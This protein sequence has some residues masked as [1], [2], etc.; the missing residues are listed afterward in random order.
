MRIDAR[1]LNNGAVVRVDVC[2]IGAG[3]AGMT[4][5][6][7]LAGMQHK[8]A[9]LESGGNRPD[10]QADELSKGELSGILDQPLHD[11]HARQVGGTANH[12]IIKMADKRNG[13][14]HAP[15]D[16]IDFE[17]REH[18]PYSGW[19]I[20]RADLDPYYRRV[21]EACEIGPY[22]YTGA[23][24][25]DAHAP[26]LLDADETLESSVFTFG[27]TN[28]FTHDWPNQFAQSDTVDL[29]T[30]AT[31]VELLTDPN[32][33]RV[34]QALVRVPGGNEIRFEATEFVIAAGGFDTARLLLNSNR[35]FAHGLGN[36]HD[37]VGRYYIDHGVVLHGYF[38]PDDL[39][40]MRRLAF[41]DLRLVGASSVLGKFTLS[42]ATRRA[43][44][45]RNLG[46]MIFPKPGDVDQEAFES[47]QQ[48]AW[49]L[50]GR[51]WPAPLGEKL[52]SI[53]RGW[54]YLAHV[55]YQRFGNDAGLMPGLA[56]GGWSEL[57]DLE[58]RFSRLELISLVE[59]TPNPNN[60]VTLLDDRDPLGCRRI[61]AHMD[62]N[63]D[64][65]ASVRR[66]EALLVEALQRGGFGRFEPH[67]PGG[68][69][70]FYSRTAHHIMGTAR[71]CDD[72]RFGVVDRDCKVHD[73]AN[74]H[75]ASSA[76]FPT[77]GYANP[78]LT[79]L[80]LTIRL[81]DTIKARLERSPTLGGEV[82]EF[83][84]STGSPE[85]IRRCA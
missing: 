31:V 72:P 55:F 18:I 27:A 43:E 57:A 36:Q 80:A 10:R 5:A 71:M 13:F 50:H 40:I 46:A 67:L 2:V 33:L 76:V 62:W 30:H 47:L 22:D 82:I 20:D 64:D 11:V 1:S 17:S 21:H 77:G 48:I 66:S 26:P 29:Y 4:F 3:P 39:A 14:R 44:R 38:Y 58:R 45:L 24:W 51:R 65:L 68:E 85:S 12:W 28:F 34:T 23:Y 56:Q 35:H 61:K 73:V 9:L 19:P 75:V 79:I 53:A 42:D 83:P 16:P 81:A 54:R 52:L 70:A 63:A 25:Q 69:I 32:G 8:V 78:T 84:A 74:L 7:E 6:H 49:A 37:V 15:L 59:Q 60:R 41:Y